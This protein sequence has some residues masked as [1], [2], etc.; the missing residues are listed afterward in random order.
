MVLVLYSI[1]FGK[2]MRAPELWEK[3]YYRGTTG[4]LGVKGKVQGALGPGS[5]TWVSTRWQ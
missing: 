4:R 2:L 1:G 3:H 5:G